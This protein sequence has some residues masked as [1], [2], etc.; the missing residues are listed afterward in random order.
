V[1]HSDQASQAGGQVAGKEMYS[2]WTTCNQHASLGNDAMKIREGRK[3]ND[4]R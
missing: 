2:V 4:V 1:P 3:E